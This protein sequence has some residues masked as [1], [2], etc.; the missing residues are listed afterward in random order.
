MTEEV[1]NGRLKSY[2]IFRL[3]SRA[4]RRLYLLTVY[5]YEGTQK[6][7]KDDLKDGLITVGS[8]FIYNNEIIAR[9]TN[10]IQ[11]K[12]S[13]TYREFLRESLLVR[14]ISSLETFFGD[15][16]REISNITT[17]PFK[18]EKEKTYKVSEL[19][20]IDDILRIHDDIL[21]NEIRGIVLGG[22]K[23]I[24]KFFRKNLDIEF[25]NSGLEIS[26]IEQMYDI[27]NL[28]VH[29]NGRVDELYIRKYF[30]G[31]KPSKKK[32]KVDEEQFI[33]FIELTFD[34][35]TYINKEMNKKFIL[36]E[37]IERPKDKSQRNNE[38]INVSFSG[39]FKEGQRETILAAEYQFG[40]K[41]CFVFS[42]IRSK[43]S[44]DGKHSATWTVEGPRYKVGTYRAYIRRLA[45][46]G[47]IN[48]LI[49]DE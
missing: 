21:N 35:S 37:K 12:L 10:E 9:S 19:L 13:D 4:L 5:A 28:I 29:N 46:Q 23:N 48:N 7:I 1:R 17:M 8:E 41:E 47:I 34:L 16:L 42:E 33:K 20:S 6:A 39:K 38:I 40:F 14:L 25:G 3:E 27:R 15:T 24:R 36:P 44:F 26:L 11:K 45:K 18:S 31:V 22:F 30:N 43:I 49:I 2:I 32:I